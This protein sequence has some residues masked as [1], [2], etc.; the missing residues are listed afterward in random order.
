MQTGGKVFIDGVDFDSLL[1]DNAQL[2]AD[3][4]QLKADN[5]GLQRAVTSLSA[6]VKDLQV[7]ADAL[8]WRTVLFSLLR[9]EH[10]PVVNGCDVVHSLHE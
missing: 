4:M 3:N 5:M 1:E 7:S 6:A 8:C 10:R 2:K 9:R